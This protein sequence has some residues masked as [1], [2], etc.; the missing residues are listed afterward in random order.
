MLVLLGKNQT[1]FNEKFAYITCACR[2]KLQALVQVGET[3]EGEPV[4]SV[5]H[6]ELS[7]I[8]Q[9]HWKTCKG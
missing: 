2:R 5:D 4:F 6:D 8:S 7:R 1:E 3:E 9:E